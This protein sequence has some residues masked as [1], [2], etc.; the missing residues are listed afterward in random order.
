MDRLNDEL[1][2]LDEARRITGGFDRVLARGFARLGDAERAALHELAAAVDGS[3][4]GAAARESVDALLGGALLPHH[5][6]V[7]AGCRAAIEG[8][9]HDAIFARGAEA[10]GLAPVE[11]EVEEAAAPSAED[12]ALM[13]SARQWLMEIALAGLGQLERATVSPAV[14]GLRHLQASPPLRRLASLLTGFVH[15]LL[16]ATPTAALAVLPQRRWGDLFTRALLATF[17][18]PAR[19]RAR[20]VDGALRPLGADVR[21]HDH[22]L[23]VVVHGLLTLDG[24]ER[25]LVRTTLSTWK[26]DAIAGDELW[27][28]LAAL[29]PPLVDA[30]REPV[31]LSLAGAS[32]LDTGDLLWDGEAAAGARFAPWDCDLGGATVHA[33]LPRDRH[34]MLVGMPLVRASADLSSGAIDGVPLD[35]ERVSPHARLDGVTRAS[36]V[37]ALLRFDERFALQPLAAR[38]GKRL[39]GPAEG[40]AGAA[41]VKKPALDVLR[42]RASKLLRA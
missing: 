35:L 28:M 29:A 23:S 30:L 38:D 33:P 22:L 9:R 5:L 20:R 10:L 41:K 8:A 40:V 25:H 12:A 6:G 11:P 31:E 4:L 36:G 26:V 21:H 42:E 18:L 14:H 16:D 7:L 3:P 13:E 32:L 34:P 37:V 1:A 19:A 17:A 24:G 2:A 27:A 39:R 15:E